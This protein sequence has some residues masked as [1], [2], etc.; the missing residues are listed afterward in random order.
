MVRPWD[1]R[2][3]GMAFAKPAAVVL[4]LIQGFS[5]RERRGKGTA[6][7]D[8]SVVIP[9]SCGDPLASELSER[10]ETEGAL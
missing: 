10:A 5:L 8:P 1:D 4:E 2:V 7:P 3:R 6:A 9:A